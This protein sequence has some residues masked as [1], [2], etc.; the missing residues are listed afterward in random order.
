MGAGAM[1]MTKKRTDLLASA[2]RTSSTFLFLALGAGLTNA[3]GD[4]PFDNCQARRTCPPKGGSAGESGAEPVAGSDGSDFGG[5]GGRGGSG[6]GGAPAAGVGGAAGGA[7]EGG[8]APGEGGSSPDEG[9]AENGGRSAAGANGDSGGSTDGGSGGALA[10]PCTPNPCENGGTCTGAGSTNA[11]DCAKGFTGEHCEFPVFEGI[12]VVGDSSYLFAV[13]ADGRFAG[14][15]DST[16][17]LIRSDHNQ[18]LAT[19]T[20]YT[21]CS[22]AAVNSDGSVPVGRCFGTEGTRAVRW[23]G[24]VVEELTP[25]G[26][27]NG[28]ASAVSADGNTVVG[29]LRRTD[30]TVPFRWTAGSGAVEIPILSPGEATYAFATNDAGNIVVGLSGT[31]GFR[32][33]IGSNPERIGTRDCTP[34]GINADGSVIVGEMK[35]EAGNA[36]AFRWTETAGLVDLGVLASDPETHAYAVSADG[37]TIVGESGNSEDGEGL[38]WTTADGLRPLK[39]VLSEAGADLSGWYLGTAADVSADGKVIVGYGR[40]DGQIEGWIAHLP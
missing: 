18:P 39:V 29:Y 6:P 4:D 27:G 33:T 30:T 40:R 34:L 20:G 23:V 32:W 28:Y 1:S 15:A 26:S 2:R 21:G 25:A 35:N 9:G 5:M 31:Q 13:S 7:A 8:A 3:C 11:C 17:A 19:P 38:I 36:H 24:G 12:G 37:N 10:E 22:V 14:G 16:N